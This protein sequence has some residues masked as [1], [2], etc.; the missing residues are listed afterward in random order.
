MYPFYDPYENLH[1]EYDVYVES[2]LMWAY[3]MDIVK[4]VKRRNV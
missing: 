2:A 4:Y 3:D 1:V